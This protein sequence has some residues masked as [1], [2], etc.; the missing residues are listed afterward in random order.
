[1]L[2]DEALLVIE[3]QNAATVTELSIMQLVV[4]SILDKK[5]GKSLEKRLKKLSIETIPRSIGN[6]LETVQWPPPGYIQSDNGWVPPEVE[7]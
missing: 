3:R 4:A 7:E 5:A 6:E 2:E 1:M